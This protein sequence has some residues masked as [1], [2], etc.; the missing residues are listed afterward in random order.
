MKYNFCLTS[1]V[2]TN[3]TNIVE[4]IPCAAAEIPPGRYHSLHRG[5]R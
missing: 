1:D 4:L 2:L 3:F 5:P